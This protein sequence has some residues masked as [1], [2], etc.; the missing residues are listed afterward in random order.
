MAPYRT[1]PISGNVG[2]DPGIAVVGR[3]VVSL[4]VSGENIATKPSHGQNI[5]IFF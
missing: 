3:P 4:G 5:E 1:L 2:G